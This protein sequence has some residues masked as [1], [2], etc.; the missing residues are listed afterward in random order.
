MTK[1]KSIIEL[2]KCID[3][4]TLPEDCIRDLEYVISLIEADN[5]VMRKLVRQFKKQE[6]YI[7]KLE[8]RLQDQ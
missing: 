2:S 7:R 1:F 8:S 3:E 6:T 4:H 5:T